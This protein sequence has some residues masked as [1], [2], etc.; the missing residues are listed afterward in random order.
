MNP[1]IDELDDIPQAPV[2]TG[3]AVAAEIMDVPA[4]AYDTVPKMG[5]VMPAGTY[6]FR[7]EKYTE[8][9]Y[10]D[11]PVYSLQWRCQQEPHTGRVAFSNCPWPKAEDIKL[12][13]DPNAPAGPRQEAQKRVN[14]RLVVSKAIQEAAGIKPGTM[15]FKQFLNTNPELFLQLGVTEKK[16]RTGQFDAKNQPIFKGTGEQKNK[17]QKYVPLVRPR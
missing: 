11:G 17:V 13:N 12:A 16:E 1:A 15:P 5:D 7:L 9:A 8:Q 6:H 4:E 3:A 10:E 14:D 2:A